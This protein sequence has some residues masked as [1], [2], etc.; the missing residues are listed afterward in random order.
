[1]MSRFILAMVA[2]LLTAQSGCDVQPRNLGGPTGVRLRGEIPTDASRKPPPWGVIGVEFVSTDSLKVADVLMK[3]PASESGIAAGDV[4]KSF[5]G[6]PVGNRDQLLMVMMNSK[7]EETVQVEVMRGDMA[8]SFE[9]RLI[10]FQEAAALR[11]SS[12]NQAEK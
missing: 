7:P 3:G 1:M 6:K 11:G 10:S 5:A 8:H 9:V 4:I 2:V 12:T